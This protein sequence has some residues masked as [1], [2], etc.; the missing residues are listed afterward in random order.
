MHLPTIISANQT[1]GLKRKILKLTLLK[2]IEKTVD[3]LLINQVL[4]N[5]YGKS[6]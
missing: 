6:L 5:L 3:E 2:Q 4:E 1:S